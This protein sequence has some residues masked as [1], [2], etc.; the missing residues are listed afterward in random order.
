MGECGED[1]VLSGQGVASVTL[2]RDPHYLA[3]RIT[4]GTQHQWDTGVGHNT[5]KG[6]HS[7]L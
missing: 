3:G 2:K 1:S 6:Q 5:R 7:T 4:S